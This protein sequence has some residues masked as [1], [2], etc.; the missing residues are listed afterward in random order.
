MLYSVR[1]FIFGNYGD[2][3]IAVMQWAYEQN[4][5]DVTV[6]HTLTGW[7]ANT[8][9]ERIAQGQQRAKEYDFNVVT[10]QPVAD[11]SSLI[12]DRKS[13]PNSKFQW[14]PSF[15]KALPFLNWLDEVDPQCEATILLGS[16]Q[17]DSEKRQ[18]LT[19]FIEESEHYGERK[20]WHPLYNYS[21]IQ[22]DNL[23]T[24]ANFSI[25]N[26]RSLECHPCIHS[27][28]SEIKNLDQESI[29]RLSNLEKEINDNM[30]EM[31]IQK[32]INEAQ[33]TND[34]KI[35]DLGCGANFV[36]GE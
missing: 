22:R 19:E 5:S 27:S 20:I 11:F 29:L 8:W 30:F 31:P 21:K 15:L 13:F 10:L 12:R 6:I 33:V 23:I 35:V 14:C 7:M 1:Y 18:N 32:L 9:N 24:K 28:L 2:N 34:K 36:C 4:F 25:L 17:A 3:T 16:R 26:H